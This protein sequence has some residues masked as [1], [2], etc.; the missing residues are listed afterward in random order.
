MTVPFLS[1]F[2]LSEDRNRDLPVG[3]TLEALIERSQ[4]VMKTFV[5]SKRRLCNGLRGSGEALQA[6]E[7]L[8]LGGKI[9]KIV[10]FKGWHKRRRQDRKS[11]DFERDLNASSLDQHPRDGVDT[12]DRFS[13]SLEVG[14]RVRCGMIALVR[15]LCIQPDHPLQRTGMPEYVRSVGAERG[16][17]EGVEPPFFCS[18]KTSPEPQQLRAV[19]QGD[20][21]Q[22]P[23][24]GASP[25]GDVALIPAQE[26]PG[27]VT[28][29]II[30][31]IAG[32]SVAADRSNGMVQ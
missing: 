12:N 7:E 3:L 4:G 13:V 26:L 5:A 27:P 15:H 8:G 11:V 2:F 19:V 21:R 32:S 22:V 18:R 29:I 17:R 20:A 23:R 16:V 10:Q 28:D 31:G 1:N 9:A 6:L 14:K 30:G 24:D 25:V